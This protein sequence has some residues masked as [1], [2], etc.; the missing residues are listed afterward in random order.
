MKILLKLDSNFF[1]DEQNH[2]LYENMIMIDWPLPFLP[3][4][5]DLFDA[6]SIIEDIP[7]FVPILSWNVSFISY[8]KKDGVIMPVLWIE[9]Q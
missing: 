8:T 7:D 6:D 5:D 2:H 1:M 4:K 9:G 3:N